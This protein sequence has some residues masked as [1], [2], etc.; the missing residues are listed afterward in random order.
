MGKGDKRSRRGKIFA[1]SH[2]KTRPKRKNTPVVPQAKVKT[3]A[4]PVKEKLAPKVRKKE[5]ASAETVTETPAVAEA[6]APAAES[7][8]VAAEG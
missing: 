2:G 1:G 7:E 8:P 6:D 3:I 5:A 4:T